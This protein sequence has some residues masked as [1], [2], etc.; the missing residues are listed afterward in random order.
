VCNDKSTQINEINSLA[1]LKWHV[2]PVTTKRNKKSK[3]KS[4]G[5][6]ASTYK[7]AYPCYICPN[8]DEAMAGLDSGDQRNL[9]C[10]TVG[11]DTDTTA[12]TSTIIRYIGHRVSYRDKL[13]RVAY[14]QLLPY[15]VFENDRNL[16]TITTTSSANQHE[17][18]SNYNRHEVDNSNNDSNN[19]DTTVLLAVNCDLDGPDPNQMENAAP[20]NPDHKKNQW[21][22][23]LMALY[24]KSLRSTQKEFKTEDGALRLKVEECLLHNITTTVLEREQQQHLSA[25]LAKQSELDDIDG[26]DDDDDD[27]DNDERDLWKLSKMEAASFDQR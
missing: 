10:K 20:N 5:F 27:D 24:M 17:V 25:T 26:D 19:G 2:V 21:N 15:D 18:N 3:L 6:T 1:L 22:S 11:K 7:V 16:T 8:Q 23:E 14:K 13:S 9:Q 4:N 12:A